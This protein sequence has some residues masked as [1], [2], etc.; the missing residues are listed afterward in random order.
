M[1]GPGP[2]T[3]GHNA[4][5][6]ARWEA[7]WRRLERAQSRQHWAK[8]VV[9][10]ILGDA[11]SRFCLLFLVQ[12]GIAGRIGCRV[13]EAGS[14]SGGVSLALARRGARVALVDVSA[15]A[16]QYSAARFSRAGLPGSVQQGDIFALPFR[17]DSFDLVWNAGVIE[18]FLPA[19]R[20]AA[21]LEMVRVCKPE[22]RI[23]VLVP[24]R[25]APFYRWGKAV[26]ERRG[27]WN[28]GYEEPLETMMDLW[29][30]DRVSVL[31]ER[32]CGFL[33]Q[34]YFLKHLLPAQ[35]KAFR[36]A[37]RGIVD[38]ANWLLWPLNRLPGFILACVVVKR[39]PGEP[40][41]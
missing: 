3:E 9:N 13:L 39:T 8:A 41:R 10:K 19:Q 5:V 40:V 18:H 38:I 1:K 32:R 11:V 24:W 27:E 26:G 31:F 29:P 17:D 6:A 12:H 22:G 34:F 25:G 15:A 30:S 33:L 21:L 4:D 23:V 7:I 36:Y 16:V 20:S 28:P 14:G 37:W 35:P 2:A